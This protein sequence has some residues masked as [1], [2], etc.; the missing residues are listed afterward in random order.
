MK[1]MKQVKWK[2]NMKG[3]YTN[4]NKAMKKHKSDESRENM[5]ILRKKKRKRNQE[6]VR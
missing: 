2:V 6:K 3:V 1:E 4:V 5:M